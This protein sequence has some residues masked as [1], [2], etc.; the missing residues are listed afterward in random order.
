M[1]YYF[2]LVKCPSGEFI[3]DKLRISLETLLFSFLKIINKSN[4][5]FLYD[6]SHMLKS[7]T[8]LPFRLLTFIR[9]ESSFC[10]IFF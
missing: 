3:F 9:Y 5:C 7:F 6:S 4:K 2:C 10:Y 1:S 8:L